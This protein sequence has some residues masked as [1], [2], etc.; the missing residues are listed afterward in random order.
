MS[1]GT[2]PRLSPAQLRSFKLSLSQWQSAGAFVERTNEL[3][4]SI[5]AVQ[6]FNDGSLAFARDASVGARL[7]SVSKA[8]EVRLC[9]GAWPDYEERF[10]TSVEQY[11]ITEAL[12]PGRRRGEEWKQAEADGFPLTHD[13]GERWVERARAAPRA[14]HSA[15]LKKAVKR[16]PPTAS[17]IVYLNIGVYGSLKAETEGALTEC[18]ACAKDH[19]HRVIVLWGD[20]LYV[21]W[22]GGIRSDLVIPLPP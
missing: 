10:G 22:D 13:P 18:T 17:L 21:T 7:A 20:R 19:F 14:V 1:P 15:A 3:M 11:E 2:R 6:F 8:D 9:H 4:D 16:Y 12:M 5:G